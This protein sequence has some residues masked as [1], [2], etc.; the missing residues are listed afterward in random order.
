MT[1]W[2]KLHTGSIPLL[3]ESL[4]PSASSLSLRLLKFCPITASAY[5]EFLGPE[6][7]PLSL[8]LL[9]LH[10]MASAF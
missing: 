5:P 3:P 8:C 7:L 4:H 10:F 6:A 1:I 9:Q 2:V